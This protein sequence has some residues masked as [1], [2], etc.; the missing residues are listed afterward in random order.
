MGPCNSLLATDVLINSHSSR[1]PLQL[2]G[3]E[4]AHAAE[5]VSCNILLYSGIS[6]RLST[7]QII[8]LVSWWRKHIE[9]LPE[10][11]H[12]CLSDKQEKSSKLS[13]IWRRESYVLDSGLPKTS[14]SWKDADFPRNHLSICLKSLFT[15]L[16]TRFCQNYVISMRDQQDGLWNGVMIYECLQTK[17]WHRAKR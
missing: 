12:L 6:L 16:L 14:R 5:W 4:I 11:L 17:R 7:W 13:F 1:F 8:Y 9:N 3:Y 15:L 2:V 10:M